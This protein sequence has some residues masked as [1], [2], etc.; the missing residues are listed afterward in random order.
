MLVL[1]IETS[2]HEV[3]F[4]LTRDCQVV[5]ERVH[6]TA[7]DLSCNITLWIEELLR[8]ARVAVRQVDGIGVSV[9]PGSWTSLRI[10]VSTGKA[11][12]QALRIPAVGIGTFDALAQRAAVLWGS[13]SL[14]PLACSRRDEVFAG[15]YKLARGQWQQFESPGAYPL[16]EL[17]DRLP[18]LES[19]VHVCG[20]GARTYREAIRQRFPDVVECEPLVSHASTIAL[21]A[22]SRMAVTVCP[23]SLHSVKPIYL[24]PSQ[25]ELR[26]GSLVTE[27]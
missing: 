25:A 9:G 22:E 2:G 15:F 18:S 24:L 14:I 7:K 23:Q 17:L 4:A 16:T 8:E 11:L 3:S 1:G 20:D 27:S 13:G 5:S 21:L 6:P 26:A 10:G 12:A 19:P